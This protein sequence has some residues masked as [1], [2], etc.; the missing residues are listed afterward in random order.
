MFGFLQIII[1]EFYI[2]PACIKHSELSKEHNTLHVRTHYFLLQVKAL[3][4]KKK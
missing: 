1:R 3:I 4:L 2:K